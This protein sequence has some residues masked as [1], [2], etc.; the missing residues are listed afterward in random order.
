[1]ANTEEVSEILARAR[2]GDGE[3]VDQ[4]APLVYEELRAAA[5]RQLRRMR[6]GQT[7]DT[8]ALVHEAYLKLVDGPPAAW[9]DRTHFISVAAVAMRH[10]LVDYARR[11]ATQKRGGDELRVTLDDHLIGATGRPL[12]LLAVNEALDAL[13][14]RSERLSRL[15]E[16]RFFGELSIEETAEVLGMS[17]RTVKRDWRKARAFLFRTLSSPSPATGLVGEMPV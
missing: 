9:Q 14:E 13:A 7:L 8:T 6:P 1:M 2:Q 15:V 11:R 10:L 17:P 3:A 4:L 16:L 12:E 5:R